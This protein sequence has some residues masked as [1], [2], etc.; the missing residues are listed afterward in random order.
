VPLIGEEPV[1]VRSKIIL[2]LLMKGIIW[3]C[4]G[5]KKSC[6][7]EFLKELICEENLDFIGLQETNRN[8]FNQTWLEGL[9]GNRKFIWVVACPNGRPRAYCLVLML[10]LLT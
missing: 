3:K 6:K 1:G 7:Y 9:C 2:S 4:Q 8:N 5:L 10:I